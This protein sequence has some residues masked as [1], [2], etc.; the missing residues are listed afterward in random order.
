MIVIT[1]KGR[2]LNHGVDCVSVASCFCSVR[3][4]NIVQYN[5]NNHDMAE[6]EL[7]QEVCFN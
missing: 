6:F 1:R 2:L 5:V 4:T 3:P 7:K